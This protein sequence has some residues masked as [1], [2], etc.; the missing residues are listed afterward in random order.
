MRPLAWLD[1]WVLRRPFAGRAAARYARQRRGFGDFDA[2]L[3][4]RMQPDLAR[5]RVVLDLGA[6]AGELATAIRRAHPDVAVVTVEP[7][8]AYGAS[9]SRALR[10]RGEAL[11]LATGVVDVAVCLSSLRHVRERAAVLR[12]LRRVVS[13]SGAVYIAELDPGAD[14]ARRD[15]HVRGMSSSIA[16]AAFAW[17]VLPTC[18]SAE[19][20]EIE[21]RA[22][23]WRH[24]DWQPDRRQPLYVM[25]LC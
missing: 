1:P 13:P 22:A 8:A 9:T 18:P 4:A 3:I 17:I 10:A 5:A 21:A 15:E 16:R 19:H 12:E 14:A 23:G 25:R 6:G 2:R 7:S 24:V 11:P 20:F